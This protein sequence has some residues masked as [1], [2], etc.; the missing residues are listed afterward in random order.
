MKRKDA[1]HENEPYILV[2]GPGWDNTEF[3]GKWILAAAKAETLWNKAIKDRIFKKEVE[4]LTVIYIP[5]FG[6]A[7]IFFLSELQKDYSSFMVRLNAAG[8]EDLQEVEELVVMIEMGFFIRK[9]QHY[10]MAIPVEL[11]MKKVKMAALKFV[12]TADEESLHPESLVA[13][14]PYAKAKAWQSRQRE[15]YKLHN[16]AEWLMLLNNHPKSIDIPNQRSN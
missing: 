4:L 6:K 13:T 1:I 3:Y 11:D 9:D 8:F 15:L 10:Q 16:R 7:A 14:M 5:D 2:E 12:Q